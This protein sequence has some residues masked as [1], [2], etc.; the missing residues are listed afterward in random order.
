V[1]S[2][3]FAQLAILRERG[4][5]A[6]PVPLVSHFHVLSTPGAFRDPM[7]PMNY[8]PFGIET[9]GNRLVVTFIAARHRLGV[10]ITSTL[11]PAKSDA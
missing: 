10:S 8:Y 9:I 6:W 2:P 4:D 11:P 3:F 5:E 7:L 1:S